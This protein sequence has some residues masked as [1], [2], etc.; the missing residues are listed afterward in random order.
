MKLQLSS[1]FR[2][3]LALALI[4]TLSPT[5]IRAETLNKI[6][7]GEGVLAQVTDSGI[8]GPFPEILTEAARRIGQEI[9]IVPMPWR[10]A[11][12]LA[13]EEAGAGAATVTRV[14]SREPLYVWVEEYMPLRLTFFV[15]KDSTLYPKSI[16]DLKGVKVAV[17][18][19]SAADYFVGGLQ[20]HGI[21]IEPV[22]RPELIPRM[23]KADR[24]EGWLIW[25][26]IGMENF[27]Q[28]NMLKDVR[29]TFNQVLGPIYLATNSSV[30]EANLEKWRA[31]LNEM[32]ADGTIQAIL[33]S[34]YGDL[35]SPQEL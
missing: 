14:P 19:G 12:A 26:I 28:Q 1:L 31:A 23:M 35:A 11:Q 32:K 30:S 16:E 15:K 34:Y 33:E 3:T 25:D 4:L 17:E 6:Y 20:D 5:P 2:S 24:V 7:I 10:R 29:R 21:K 13:Q 8:V 27:R 9:K 18:R 22:T